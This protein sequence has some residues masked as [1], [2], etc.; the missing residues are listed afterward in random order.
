LVIGV[1]AVLSAAYWRRRPRHRPYDVLLLLAFIFLVRCLL[2][3]FTISYHHAPFLLALAG[4]EA[5]S[6]RGLPFLT[7]YAAAGL[8]AISAVVA[9]L[10]DPDSLYRAY[11]A[12]ALP[13]A[14]YMGLSL[15][16]PARASAWDAPL[17]LPRPI[18]SLGE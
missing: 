11:V 5:V 14:A 4:Y 15:Y 17:R 6:R 12:W 8:W 13:L 16:L 3:P 7:I 1:A 9:P 18:A 2:D 10:G